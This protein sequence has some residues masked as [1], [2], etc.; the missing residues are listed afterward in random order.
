MGAFFPLVK[1]VGRLLPQCLETVNITR[2]PRIIYAPA[3][4]ADD[5]DVLVFIVTLLLVGCRFPLRTY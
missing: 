3:R 5:W 2:C 1:V 4:H